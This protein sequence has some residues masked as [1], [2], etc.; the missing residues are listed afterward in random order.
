MAVSQL[1]AANIGGFT[2]MVQYPGDNCCTIYRDNYFGRSGAR[3][4]NQD[5]DDYRQTFCHSGARTAI[6]LHETGW[7][8]SMDSWFC[9]KNVWYDF[10]HNGV[11]DRCDSDYRK[12]AGAG[13]MKNRKIREN[14]NRTSTL[15]LGPYDPRQIGAVTLFE[16]GGCSGN[17]GR[18]YWD[19][20]SGPSG[21]F[22]NEEDIIYGGL[23]N[24]TMSSMAVP[25]GYIVEVY[26]GHG[27][28]EDMQRVVGSFINSGEEMIC[29]DSTF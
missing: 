8:D 23:S 28:D 24:N 29:V 16:D 26:N 21:T 4:F 13:H 22:Y 20:E 18:F 1:L 12:Y 11:N 15:I 10:C 2:P 5:V 3:E 27:F 6:N 19:P 14:S 25:A 9:G 7:G 17:S